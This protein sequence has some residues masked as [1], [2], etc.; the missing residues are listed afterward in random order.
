MK[1]TAC[2][3]PHACLL[4]SLLAPNGLEL[5]VSTAVRPSNA[6]LLFTDHPAFRRCIICVTASVDK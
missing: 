5:Y 3:M 2:C 4:L 1:P 6:T